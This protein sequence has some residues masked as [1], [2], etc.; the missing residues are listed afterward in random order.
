MFRR[1]VLLLLPVLPLCA[2]EAP[3]PAQAEIEAVVARLGADSPAARDEAHAKLM[4]MGPAALEPV[5]RALADSAD[6]EIRER[7]RRLLPFF[8]HPERSGLMQSHPDLSE[9][10]EALLDEDPSACILVFRVVMAD[11]IEDGKF[12]F[13]PVEGLKVSFAPSDKEFSEDAEHAASTDGDGIWAAALIPGQSRVVFALSDPPES[14]QALTPLMPR[15]A[16]FRN[17]PGSFVLLSDLKLVPPM[18][19]ATPETGARFKAPDKP[20]FSWKPYP[21]AVSYRL[22]FIRATRTTQQW[23]ISTDTVSEFDVP[24]DV[25]SVAWKQVVEAAKQAPEGFAWTGGFNLDITPLDAKGEAL[26]GQSPTSVSVQVNESGE[27]R[28][29][30]SGAGLFFLDD[31]KA[32]P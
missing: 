6:P 31:E 14:L 23:R 12:R 16:A 4:R 11:G 29:Q 15:P 21:G 13:K 27:G 25:T 28:M 10:V 1:A 22:K 9:R 24:G 8:E 26:A 17:Q 19:Q 5:R 7:C 18:V 32:A 30:I 2:D 3:P 20:T